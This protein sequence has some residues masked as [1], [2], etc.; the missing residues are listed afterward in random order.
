MDALFFHAFE[1]MGMDPKKV[2]PP[3]FTALEAG[4]PVACAGLVDM[5]FGRAEAWLMVTERLNGNGGW[6]ARE[7]LKW[8]DHAIESGPFRRIQ[9]TVPVGDTRLIRWMEFL[10]FTC[11]SDPPQ[12]ILHSY[13]TRGEDKLMYARVRGR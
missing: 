5:G 1:A 13:G 9:A 3:A 6:V 8:L 11:E 10:G 4:F 2:P 12:H 7:T